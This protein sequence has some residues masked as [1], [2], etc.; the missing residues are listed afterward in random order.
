VG[1]PAVLMGFNEN[2][3]WTHTV[4]GSKQMVMYH[5]TLDPENS[6]RYQYGVDGDGHPVYKDMLAK[7]HTIQVLNND[8]STIAKTITLYSSHYGPIWNWGYGGAITFRDANQGNHFMLEQW[9]AMDKAN[10]LEELTQA[11]AHYQSIPWVDTIATGK[12]GDAFFMDGSKTANLHPEIDA[13][14]RGVL[15]DPA[16]TQFAGLM[17]AF[18]QEGDGQLILNGS[19]PLSEWIDTGTTPTSGQVPFENAPRLLTSDYA[20]NANGSHWLSNVTNKLEGY[21]II[22][23]PEATVRSPRTRMNAKM[24]TE[25]SAQGASGVDGKF[26]FDELKNVVTG[27]RAI[28]S[29]LL[30]DQLVARCTGVTEA[31]LNV[32]EAC[33]VLTHWDGLFKN[34]SVGAHIFREFLNQFNSGTARQLSQELFATP[35]N[36]AD[37]VNTPSDLKDSQQAAIN[38]PILLAL[39][40]AVKT[41]AAND[42]DLHS[43]LG[44]LQ[45]HM[46]NAE[47]ISIPGGGSVEGVFNINLAHS[48]SDQG[49]EV[50]HGASW[51]MALE[52]TENGPRADAFLAYSQSHDPESEFYA[53]QTRLYSNG[54]WRAVR[55]SKED[56]KANLVKSISL[57]TH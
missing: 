29:E 52:F 47:R 5:L 46:K 11:H 44:S 50:F 3:A 45:F 13:S 55:F 12:S 20:Y 42:I 43:P 25:V 54:E 6:T 57:Q 36:V 8:G 16:T 27:E 49:Y 33:T 48:I 26:S 19:D 7:Q 22:Y 35:F 17:Q 30:K 41:L 14:I 39:A 28:T 34:S 53:D 18:W 37:P 56:I 15:Y 51:V 4:S 40:Q 24:L 2:V 38:D 10:N 23:G 31:A 21:P 9:L 1:I 32:V